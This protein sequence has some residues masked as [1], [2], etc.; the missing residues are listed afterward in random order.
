MAWGLEVRVPFLDMVMNINPADK[1]CSFNS[2][3]KYILRQAFTI[4]STDFYLFKVLW[5]QKEQFSDCVGYSWIDSLREFT[6]SRISE[7]DFDS[8]H[9][10]SL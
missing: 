2:I 5:S 10:F 4:L 9:H 1:M 7:E 6:E 3:E 8:Q